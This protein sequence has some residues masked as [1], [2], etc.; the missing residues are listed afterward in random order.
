MWN[1]SLSGDAAECRGEGICIC[2]HLSGD[3]PRCTMPALLSGDCMKC[4]ITLGCTRSMRS[5]WP[6]GEC[7]VAPFACCFSFAAKRTVCGFGDLSTDCTVGCIRIRGLTGEV[8]D[9]GELQ[10]VRACD[11]DRDGLDWHFGVVDG[12]G[13][14]EASSQRILR[15]IKSG[16]CCTLRNTRSGVWTPLPPRGDLSSA[17]GR[18]QSTRCASRKCCGE[19]SP[20]T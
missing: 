4:T 17:P 1:N 18:R 3:C 14:S 8:S 13:A 2:L 12:L 6:S 9:K 19:K 11:V 16:E 7:A 5:F 20:C 15:G 10:R